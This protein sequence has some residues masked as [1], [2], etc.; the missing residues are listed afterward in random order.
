[1]LHFPVAILLI[2]TLALIEMRGWSWVARAE[3]AFVVITVGGLVAFV[4]SAILLGRLTS[5]TFTPFVPHSVGGLLVG[6]NIAFFAYSGFNTITTLTPDVQEGEKT[7]PKAI[8]A[9]LAMS[10]LL[11]S[12]V[13]LSLL[14]ALHWSGYGM[15]ANPLALALSAVNAPTAVSLFVAFS[16]I[17]ATVTVTL[18]L[19]VAGSRVAKQMG[20][21]D[22]LPRLFGKG[23]RVPTIV[24]AGI[25]IAALGLGNVGSIALVANF[26]VIFSYLLSGVEVIVVRRRL[27]KRQFVSPGFPYLQVCSLTLSTIMLVSLGEHSL[28][29]GVVTLVVGLILHGVFREVTMRPHA[30]T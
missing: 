29:V 2:V 25:M 9:A 19:L 12:V 6:A 1:M 3:E 27:M 17:T 22:V 7:V 10:S 30:A 24:I 21:D 13:V 28:M 16:A 11:Y 5:A 14:V 4:G 15:T 26:G 23:S 20:E 18:S 8:L